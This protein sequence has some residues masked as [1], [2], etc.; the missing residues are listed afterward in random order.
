MSLTHSTVILGGGF[1]GLFTALHL[2]QKNYPYPVL[3]VDQR[4]RFTFKPLLYE[5]L[6]GEL[7]AEQICPSYIELLSDRVAFV[8]SNIQSIDLLKKQVVLASGQL[9]D[10]QHLVMALGSQTTYFNI[11]GAA[12]NALPFT[13]VTETIALKNHLETVL[14]QA[15]QTRDRSQRLNF[16]TIAIIGA[17]PSGIELACTLADILP[18]WY[19]AMG[20]NYEEIRVVLVNRS[21]EV[22]KGDVNSRLREQ[23][24]QSLATC[25]IA[26][27]LLLEAAVT[28]ITPAGVAYTRLEELSFLPAQTVVWTGGT[29]PHKLLQTLPI[30]L[31]QRDR[32]GRLQVTSTLQLP[33]FPEVFVGGDCA[34]VTDNPQPPTAQVAYQQGKASASNLQAISAKQPP[35]TAHVSLRGTLMKL[36]VGEGI[37][38]IFDRVTVSGELGHLIRE[39]TYLELLPTP[40]HN[41]KVTTEWLADSLLQRHQPHSIHPQRSKRTP[42]LAG[43][44]AVFAGCILSAPLIWRAAQPD[45]F[46]QNLSWTGIPT[47][48]NQLAPSAE[49]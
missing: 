25:T 11:P 20:G 42:V 48:L 32:Q 38:N 36:G 16:L 26:V 31:E 17:S 46:Q 43:A 40:V 10:Y 49:Q 30:P 24:K 3:L 9:L 18:V 4:D 37:A 21:S 27:E 15:C 8:Q 6:T 13:T 39:A 29:V 14:R 2:S 23:A 12:E 41:F 35:Q 5:L 47:L 34:Y 7:H 19:D 33:E 45:G 1:V 22:L 28:S 44:V